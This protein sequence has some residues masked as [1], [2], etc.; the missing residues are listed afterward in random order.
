MLLSDP[1]VS[2]LGSNVKVSRAKENRINRLPRAG[3]WSVSHNVTRVAGSNASWTM[4]R[5]WRGND[6][7]RKTQ[8]EEPS[9]GDV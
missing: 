3:V 6:A 4:V 7:R 2:G 1:L 5:P 9:S 8:I